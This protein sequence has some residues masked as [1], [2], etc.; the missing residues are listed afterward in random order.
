MK[1]KLL[2]L[3]EETVNI[4]PA[5]TEVLVRVHSLYRTLLNTCRH[6][7]QVT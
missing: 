1:D 3:A 6:E 2:E 7:R 5:Q 4:G